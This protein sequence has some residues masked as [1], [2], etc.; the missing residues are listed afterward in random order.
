VS[1]LAVILTSLWY[2]VYPLLAVI[3]GFVAK[4]TGVLRYLAGLAHIVPFLKVE[5]RAPEK[6][7]LRGV[8]GETMGTLNVTVSNMARWR[9]LASNAHNVQ[10]QL[11]LVNTV[12]GGKQRYSPI[13][14]DL[15]TKET[16]IDEMLVG[17]ECPVRLLTYYVGSKSVHVMN[18]VQT[19]I[20]SGIYRLELEV[21][22]SEYKRPLQKKYVHPCKG[23]QIINL[24]EELVGALT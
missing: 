21:M 14:W 23:S 3:L 20:E 9:F 7:V 6:Y 1:D 15:I 22:C 10:L 8:I 13:I 24:P 2:V 4:Q 18:V 19:R 12:S 5:F 17:Q 16:R 11:L